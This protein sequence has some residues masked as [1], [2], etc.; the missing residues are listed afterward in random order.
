MIANAILATLAY[1]DGFDYPLSSFELYRYCINPKRL[2]ANTK[3]LNQISLEDIIKSLDVLV[4]KGLI[5]EEG[6]FYCLKEREGLSTSRIEREKISAQKWRK[7]LRLG[8][9][10]Q[11]TPW[12]RGMFISGSLAMGTVS[13]NSDFDILV[14]VEPRRLYITRLFL[15]GS[16]SLIG[17]RRTKFE[18]IA[19]DKFCFNHYLTTDS[20]QITHESL[21]N[22][23]TYS[24]LFPIDVSQEMIGKFFAEN[25]WINKFVY[26]F[27]PIRE[28]IRRTIKPNH[29]F[30]GVAKFIETIFNNRL[31]DVLE[32]QAKEY[33]H[34]RIMQNPLTNASGGRIIYTDKELEFHPQSFEKVILGKYNDKI[35]QLGISMNTEPDSGL[36]S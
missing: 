35:R 2:D 31:G 3:V 10:L 8:Y 32:R 30:K 4:K 1:Y 20:L 26:N 11:I 28:T 36:R 21:Y 13:N 25:I 23:E 5:V 6:G 18:A 27:K 34:K 24:H 7:C 9:W 33:Q 22:A 12:V 14:L 19:P 17:A 29:F 16:A 15:L